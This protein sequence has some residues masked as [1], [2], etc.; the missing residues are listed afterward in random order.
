VCGIWDAGAGM[1]RLRGEVWRCAGSGVPEQG[2]SG[3]VGRSGG[4]RDVGYRSRGAP[5]TW[6]G[7]AVCG[8]WD[9]G[10]GMLRL[11]GEIWWCAGSGVPEQ[12][13]SGYVGEAWWFAGGSGVPEQ[14]CSGYV[15]R[16]GGGYGARRT[17]SWKAAGSLPPQMP[18]VR[19]IQYRALLPFWSLSRKTALK[20]K[21]RPAPGASFTRFQGTVHS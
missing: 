21:T 7:L 4:V 5:A 16:A 14:G 13:C 2:C 9:A 18:G 1:L 15:G 8:V 12:G 3:Y 11:R 20:P 6:G 10:A 19:P 17:K